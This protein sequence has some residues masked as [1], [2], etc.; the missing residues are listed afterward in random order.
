MRCIELRVTK[1]QNIFSESIIWTCRL[2]SRMF[3]DTNRTQSNH[4]NSSMCRQRELNAV[5][6][7]T[8]IWGVHQ[9]VDLELCKRG[10]RRDY[11][12]QNSEKRFFLKK[13]E[14]Q[15]MPNG[16]R[17]A[18]PFFQP[19]IWG[20]GISVPCLSVPNWGSTRRPPF[21]EPHAVWPKATLGNR[22]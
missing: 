7:K 5:A 17:Q 12:M 22:D 19:K 4:C 13:F 6:R 15:T 11:A 21:Q 2:M 1:T 10:G 9:R 16:G 18:A 3:S 20:S 14:G 8:K